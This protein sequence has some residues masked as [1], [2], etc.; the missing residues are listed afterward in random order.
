MLSEDG[1]VKKNKNEGKNP[2]RKEIKLCAAVLKEL[3]QKRHQVY[4]WPFYQPVDVEGLKLHDYHDV[5]K[6]PM[7]LSTIQK[8]MDEGFYTKKEEF[9][10]DVLLIFE[11]CF[12]VRP[13]PQTM[14]WFFCDL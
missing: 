11:N 7:D 13:L 5:I 10:A 2:K 1:P 9:E 3:F 4:A 8:N 14:I 12:A 6:K